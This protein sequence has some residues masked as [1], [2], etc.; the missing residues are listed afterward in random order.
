MDLNQCPGAKLI[1]QPAPEEIRCPSCGGAVEIWSDEQC[2]VCRGCGARV[3]RNGA[4]GSCLD[5]CASAKECVGEE[6]YERY[7]RGRANSAGQ[8]DRGA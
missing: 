1:R 5:W 4:K 7:V 8:Q 3:F 2:A 6:A